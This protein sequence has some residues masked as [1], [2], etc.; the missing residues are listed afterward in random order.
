MEMT[1]AK[2]RIKI[3]AVVIVGVVCL[4][5]AGCTD[6]H[7]VYT[8]APN[9]GGPPAVFVLPPGQTTP[10]AISTIYGPVTPCGHTSDGRLVV[11]IQTS[12]GG[13]DIYLADADTGTILNRVVGSWMDETCKYVTA[14]DTI[15][16]EIYDGSQTDIFAIQVGAT[17]GQ[18]VANTAKNEYFLAAAPDGHVI[19]KRDSYITLQGYDIMSATPGGSP[20]TL[21][22]VFLPDLHQPSFNAVT[23]DNHVVFSE[24]VE[25]Q[26]GSTSLNL[27]SIRTDGT[28]PALLAQDTQGAET[29]CLVTP[30]SRVFYTD[31]FIEVVDGQERSVG[32]LYSV[33]ADGTNTL[34]LFPRLNRDNDTC[35]G[36]TDFNVL[37]FS[38][39]NLFAADG[40][41]PASLYSLVAD[42]QS[43]PV[44][45]ANSTD[46][47]DVRTTNYFQK[48]TPSG[49]IIF[50]TST[51]REVPGGQEFSSTLNSVSPDGS[52][53]LLLT[54]NVGSVFTVTPAGHVIYNARVPA[55]G[56]G[57]YNLFSVAASGGGPP[58][59]LS[60]SPNLDYVNF[61]Y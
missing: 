28:N 42:G 19:F 17:I 33:K 60:S 37:I 7:I 48:A 53:A 2:S 35:R 23:A 51:T 54:D 36:I 43:Q 32:D 40:R 58:T 16:Y 26:Q 15:I 30:D 34:A 47:L 6:P 27:Y 59:Q 4:F 44:L 57:A 41:T 13:A 14:N 50:T 46:T 1:W 5:M 38:R 21:A 61:T 31:R 3:V 24:Y 18:P 22:Q 25:F 56:P 9:E 52:N 8:S 39:E 12:L 29:F 49:G 20:V 55:N 10:V 11:T 45:I